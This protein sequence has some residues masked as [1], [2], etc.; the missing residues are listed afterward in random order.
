[1]FIKNSKV[2]EF[3][4]EEANFAIGAMFAK[5]IQ[6]YVSQI[7]KLDANFYIM[8]EKLIS[9]YPK[10]YK[11]VCDRASGAKVDPDKYLAIVSYEL[12]E[13]AI[14]KCTDIIIKKDSGTILLGH[15]EDGQYNNSNSSIIK[16]ITRDGWYIEFSCIDSLASTTYLWNSKGIIFSVN[17]VYLKHHKLDEISAWFVLR[18]IVE[19]GSLEEIL[20]RVKKVKSASGFNINLIDTNINKVYS[21]EYYIDQLSVV[22]VTDKF[23]HTNHFLHLEKG[24]CPN[25]SNSFSRFEHCN[26]LLDKLDKNTISVKDIKT[27]L[28]YRDNDYF[29]TVHVDKSMGKDYLTSSLFLFDS[30]QKTIQICDYI[31]N[32]KLTFKL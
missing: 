16:Y 2:I 11:E 15:N 10:Y 31:N 7:S 22:E 14:E 23:V 18:D 1:M 9:T 29:H 20:E 24:Y 6:N 12:R 32:K 21:V 30:K 4:E 5:E 13:Q 27:I 3:R 19:C 17:Y 25:N 26:S 8:K 28:E